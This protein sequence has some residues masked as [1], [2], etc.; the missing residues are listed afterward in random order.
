MLNH[1]P[2]KTRSVFT[3]QSTCGYRN[4]VIRNVLETYSTGLK[5][6]NKDN[7]ERLEVVRGW[8]REE[9]KTSSQQSRKDYRSE[10]SIEVLKALL[11]EE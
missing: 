2:R 1:M 3:Q 6:I 11:E 8:T 7:L 4:L 9:S 5:V 10:G